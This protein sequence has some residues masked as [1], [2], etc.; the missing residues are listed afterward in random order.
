MRELVDQAGR[1]H[2]IEAARDRIVQR[3][4]VGGSSATA[5]VPP[6]GASPLA[7]QCG[8]RRAR[9][10]MDLERALDALRV[11]GGQSSRGGRIDA[12]ELGM[13]AQATLR[14]RAR[15]EA[16]PACGSARGSETSPR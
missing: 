14:P 12:R 6:S 15:V 11:G 5:T 7:L 16:A 9:E 8:D 4:A 10:V 3:G 13:Q 2:G 1:E